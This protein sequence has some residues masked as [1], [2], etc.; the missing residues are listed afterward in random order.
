MTDL[1]LFHHV[2]G[3]TGGVR[4]FAERLRERG[5]IVHTPDLFDE[6]TFPTIED[7]LGYVR[8]IGFEAVIERA[9]SACE[10]LPEEL[11][12]GGF[13][14]GVMPAQYLLQTSSRARGGLFLHGFIDPAEF[15]DHWP[16]EVPVHVHGAQQDP[17]F[18]GEGDLA[19]AQAVQATADNL[20]IFLYPGSGHLF[21]DSTTSD[22]DEQATQEVAARADELLT[23]LPDA[24]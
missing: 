11:V 9:V 8:Q 23:S 10:D 19:A 22:Y 7:G 20:E 24:S 2:R 14:L 13:S 16:D 6:R 4:A 15:G 3:L 1:V 17:F 12:F 5:H 18:V 21:T